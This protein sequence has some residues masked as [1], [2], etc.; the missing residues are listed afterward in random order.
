MNDR[1]FLS[2]LS[3][4]TQLQC[5]YSLINFF[6]QLKEQEMLQ[7]KELPFIKAITDTGTYSCTICGAILNAISQ[8][9]AHISGMSLKD[10]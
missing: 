5:I 9:Q 10:I 3:L 1:N 6:S 7:Y 4:H 8:I 2:L